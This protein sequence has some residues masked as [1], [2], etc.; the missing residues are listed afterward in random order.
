MV[1]QLS[2]W[3]GHNGSLKAAVGPCLHRGA[4]QQSLPAMVSGEKELGES[5][6][7]INIVTTLVPVTVSLP[8]L[9]WKIER[10]KKTNKK[11]NR[12]VILSS[13][14]KAENT[15]PFSLPPAG[16]ACWLGGVLGTWKAFR[17]GSFEL[18]SCC[19]LAALWIWRQEKKKKHIHIF[20]VLVSC[21]SAAE[22][23]LPVSGFFSVLFCL[24]ACHLGRSLLPETGVCVFFFKEG[25]DQLCLVSRDSEMSYPGK[26]VWK[27]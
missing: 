14:V 9:Y 27:K 16:S 19:A 6:Q 8:A 4:L 21:P 26:T 25:K 11:K 18:A 15:L 20:I 22:T 23:I 10:E 13:L 2:D 1:G 7:V 5:Q 3:W 12:P 17:I 24:L